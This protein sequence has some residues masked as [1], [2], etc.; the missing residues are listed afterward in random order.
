MY[1]S[2]AL[3]GKTFTTDTEIIIHVYRIRQ[4]AKLNS[5][6]TFVFGTV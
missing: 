5:I 3:V 4:I 6:V 2:L 1:N